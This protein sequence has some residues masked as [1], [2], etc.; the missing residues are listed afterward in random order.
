MRLDV[1]LAEALRPLVERLEDTNDHTGVQLAISR[2]FGTFTITQGLL[3]VAFAQDELGHLGELSHKRNSLGRQLTAHMA[4]HHP[5]A[6]EILDHLLF[7]I[8]K[9]VK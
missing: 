2:V 1:D 5:E 3:D 8:G 6:K 7:D 9:G 4:L